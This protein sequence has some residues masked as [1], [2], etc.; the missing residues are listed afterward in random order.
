MPV[1][2]QLGLNALLYAVGLINCFFIFVLLITIRKG[3]RRANYWLAGFFLTFSL[4]FLELIFEFT[5]I[6]FLYPHLLEILPVLAFTLGPL[7]YFYVKT[8]T[9]PSFSWRWKKLLHFAP[10]FAA[11]ICYMPL[12]ASSKEEK[13]TYLTRLYS[14]QPTGYEFINIA[15]LVCFLLYLLAS[16]RIIHYHGRRMRD[17][18]SGSLERVNLAW[19]KRLTTSLLM[20]WGLWTNFHIGDVDFL[21]VATPLI[22]LVFLFVLGFYAVR[23]NVIF[24]SPSSGS[25]EPT[26][27]MRKKRQRTGK[28][29][30][31]KTELKE[32]LS[33]KLRLLME[34]EKVFLA[35][36]LTLP[37]LAQKMAVST[38][39]LS[40]LINREHGENF[41]DFVNKYR[42]EE[43][44]RLLLDPKF[45]HY[46]ILS[47]GLQ[48]GFNSKTTFNIAFK[49]KVGH[50]P[51]EFRKT[52]L[53]TC[54]DV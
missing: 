3:N 15:A 52:A 13:L 11:A 5:N 25:L 40:E 38:N 35:G 48:A 10:F 26:K 42:V 51:A 44:K 19:L 27:E 43:S 37:E 47:I 7:Y 17:F 33:D 1:K 49:S 46:S 2:I 21:K 22:V 16:L 41:Y 36:N 9:T 6:L 8:L 24:E 28:P 18:F 54:S 31:F 23:Q 12:Y 34:E 39:V 53:S 45:D 29:A 30:N 50:T 20:V 32:E 14:E 4:L